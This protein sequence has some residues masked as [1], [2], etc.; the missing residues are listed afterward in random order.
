MAQSPNHQ[1]RPYQDISSS[2]TDFARSDP[3]YL[4]RYGGAL[5][6]DEVG[7]IFRV[8]GKRAGSNV[9]LGPKP[10]DFK[11]AKIRY[12]WHSHEVRDTIR[13]LAR[14]RADVVVAEF[15]TS[16]QTIWL[17]VG[18]ARAR[19]SSDVSLLVRAVVPLILLYV[20]KKLP[21][22]RTTI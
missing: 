17:S 12:P 19:N 5:D 2:P 21:T 20:N 1:I 22:A 14:G 3:I 18:I 6:P 4:T 9:H 7:Q 11:G 13:T 10:N 15:S 8:S 16:V